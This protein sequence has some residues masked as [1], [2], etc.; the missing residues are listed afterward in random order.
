MKMDFLD[1]KKKRRH[2]IQLLV[3]YALIAIALVLAT[4]LLLAAA[5]GYGINR[6]T[7]EVTQ[8]GLLFV[9]AHPE[10]ATI[11]INGQNKGP[12]DGRFVLETGAYTLDLKRDGYRSWHRD[13][14]IEG[15]KIVRLVYPFLF[16]SNL[17]TS[18]I[19]PQ[20]SAPDMVTESPDRHWVIVHNPADMKTFQVV[21]TSAKTPAATA[22]SVP[23]T[24]FPAHANSKLELVE[25]ST[26]NK[27][28]LLK[29]TYDGGYDYVI[30]D[31][32]TPANTANLTQTLGRGYTSMT[33]RDK[34]A[35]EVYAYDANG[36]VLQAISLKDKSATAIASHV[37]SFWPYKSD[38]IIYATDQ[39]ATAG[40]VNVYLREGQNDYLLRELAT[41]PKY[42]MNIAEFDGDTYLAVGSTGDGKEYIYKNPLTPLKKNDSTHNIP[43]LLLRLDNPD[44]VTFSANTRFIALQAGSKFEVYDAETEQQYKYDTHLP[45]DP[46]EKTAWMDGH[47]LTLVSGGKLHVFDYD[48]QNTQTLTNASPAFSP[49]FDRDYEF[50]YTFGPTNA[51]VAKSALSR[52]ELKIVKK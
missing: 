46:G 52:T 20:A 17:V 28:A 38:T 43:L 50:M 14:V 4:I 41:G 29:Y 2:A 15:S 13:F 5:L 40:K 19:L 7:G 51:D 49:L 26:N 30:F 11:Y 31:R 45:L 9:D 16:P 47:R 44:T 18:D 35:D 36:G 42:L 12:T 22:V 1:P 39:K 3:G 24:V 25:W 8:N 32:D 23:A 6:S 48:N 34:R 21:D 37:L 10:Q 27:N 33:L